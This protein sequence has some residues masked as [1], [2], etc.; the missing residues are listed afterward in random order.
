MDILDLEFQLP[1][2]KIINISKLPY[3]LKLKLNNN[4]FNIDDSKIIIDHSF[5]VVFSKIIL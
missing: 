5:N 2:V 4:C 3:W 1:A